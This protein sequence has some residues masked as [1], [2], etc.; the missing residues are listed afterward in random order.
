MVSAL[1]P[2]F[3]AAYIASG[4]LGRTAPILEMLTIEPPPAAAIRAPATA[5]SRNGPLRLTSMVLSNSPSVTDARFS[6]KRG[7]AGIVDHDVEAAEIGD[8]LVDGG[9]DRVPL[10]R[11]AVPAGSA[12]C[13]CPSPSRERP[14]LRSGRELAAGHDHRGARGAPARGRWRSPSPRLAPVTSATFPVRSPVCSSVLLHF[15]TRDRAQMDFVRAVG[16][17]QGAGDRIHPGQ[18]VSS[19]TPAAP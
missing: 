4:G 19:L 9:F 5:I 7:D 13:R 15:Q 18:H 6:A 16:D 1:R 17:L 11:H 8:D 12:C 14:P 3:A 2:F 10:A